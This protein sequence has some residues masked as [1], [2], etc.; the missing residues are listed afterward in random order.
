[1]AKKKTPDNLD[2]FILVAMLV[3]AFTGYLLTTHRPYLQ[4]GVVTFAG[5]GYVIWGIWHHKRQGNLHL[6][7]ITEYI[8]VAALAVALVV[9][10]LLLR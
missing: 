5:V 2:F 1:M 7:I 9:S 6:H 3:I 4:T 10:N 8:L